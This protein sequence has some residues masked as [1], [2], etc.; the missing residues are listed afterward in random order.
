MQS[1]F[2]VVVCEPVTLDTESDRSM[3]VSWV[4]GLSVHEVVSRRL[5]DFEKEVSASNARIGNLPAMSRVQLSFRRRGSTAEETTQDEALS[6]RRQLETLFGKD[7]AD[8][9]R[10]FDTMEHFLRQPEHLRGQLQVQLGETTQASPPAWM[11]E[12][13]HELDDSVLREI[14][15]KKVTSKTRKDLDDVSELTHV[16]L[17]SCHRQ[18][19]NIQRLLGNL[20]DSVILQHLSVAKEVQD[21]LGLPLRLSAKYTAVAFLLHV[22][23]HVQRAKRLT[24]HMTAYD[25]C[26]SAMGMLNYWVG[27]GKYLGAYEATN[28]VGSF[29][30]QEAQ[31]KRA[32]TQAGVGDPVDKDAARRE[33]WQNEMEQGLLTVIGL[34]FDKKWIR[35]LRVIKTQ[36]FGDY[37][38][39]L[40]DDLRQHAMADLQEAG[41]LPPTVEAVSQS[42]RPLVKALASIGSGLSMSKEYRDV[43][44][45]LIEKVGNPLRDA[46]L[47]LKDTVSVLESLVQ[48]FAKA[49]PPE[50]EAGE[51]EMVDAWRRYIFG[52]RMCFRYAYRDGHQGFWS[53]RSRHG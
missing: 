23:F 10:V 53:T 8:A 26:W 38:S 43:F 9:Y 41:L 12:R 45:D 20:E 7:T 49:C 24:A 31:S 27:D 21:K 40:F 46:G 2:D 51:T 1:L 50:S 39:N 28:T 29:C 3:F 22:R 13:Y 32:N 4:R 17:R 15:G 16:P 11:V 5:V 18:Y 19:D 44:E 48:G 33:G 34:E 6:Q 35:L 37:R 47:G 14:L 36:L 52:V 42:F 30:K 25:L